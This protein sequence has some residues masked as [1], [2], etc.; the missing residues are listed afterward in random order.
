[1]VHGPGDVSLGVGLDRPGRS[2]LD[3]P[4]VADQFDAPTFEA[5]QNLGY[6][7]AVAAQH[8]LDALGEEVLD[9][10]EGI[11]QPRPFSQAGVGF[12]L[13][14]EVVGEGSDALNA[15][16]IR[17]REDAADRS[18]AEE[19]DQRVGLTQPRFGQGTLVVGSD[20]LATHAS[21]RMSHEVH[22]HGARSVATLGPGE[23]SPGADTVLAVLACVL[24]GV[25]VPV[26]Q[27][28]APDPVPG[29]DEVVVALAA[30]SV[31]HRD[32]WIRQGTYAGLRFPIIPGS[33]GCGQVVALGSRADPDLLG[34]R[35][36]I[37][38]TIG[39]GDDHRVQTSEFRILGLPDD[40]TW[41][42]LVRVPAVNVVDAPDH[43]S[44]EAAAAL[45]L[46]GVTAYRALFARGDVRPGERVLVTGIGGG[47]ALFALQMAERIGAEVWVT[48]SSAA[49]RDR[50]VALGAAGG[51]DYRGA[52]WAEELRDLA[53]G[54]FH[55]V[56][57]GAGG[58]GFAEL[59]GVLE[60]AGRLVVYGAT[61][62][63]PPSVDL[64]R[65]FWRQIDLRGTTM[66]SP[67]DFLGMV[68]FVSTHHLTPVIDSVLARAEV[69]AALARMAAGDQF[70]KL[71]IASPG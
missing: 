21:L 19:R 28:V 54:G 64:R 56:V 41:A 29:P 66:G 44:D 40:G 27:R 20:P 1:M 60:P 50:A 62:G 3:R 47:V 53:G 16:E 48:S 12:D 42:E 34:R 36:V 22:R 24:D 33:D 4:L 51:V 26:V 17:A 18:V 13:D 35:V 6:H 23:G 57:D 7:V 71:V 31:N 15:T 59:A 69:E 58:E 30:A 14:P 61:G 49:K 5:H 43:L 63:N 52:D 2:L 11:G 45:P 68:R 55:L 8:G 70:G 9:Q 38:P 25:D 46:A 67:E 37:D 32:L 65:L 10:A 39:W